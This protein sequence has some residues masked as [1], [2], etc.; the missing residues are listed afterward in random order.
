GASAG[1]RRATFDQA[2]LRTP[3]GQLSPHRRQLASPAQ[4]G[5]RIPSSDPRENW[6]RQLPD[7]FR[8]RPAWRVHTT[9][10]YQRSPAAS[11]REP[12]APSMTCT[13]QSFSALA[14]GLKLF[15][16]DRG[17]ARQDIADDLPP[18]RACLLLEFSRRQL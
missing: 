14:F 16:I 9:S 7:S 12:T 17:T 6:L 11:L 18:E 5:N 13:G 3:T 10:S 1:H 4:R 15:H 8:L 2:G